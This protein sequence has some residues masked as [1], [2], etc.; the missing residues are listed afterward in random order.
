MCFETIALHD[1]VVRTNISNLLLMD[2]S[3]I[4][5]CVSVMRAL[6]I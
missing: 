3:Y 2:Y 4:E 1:V 6:K 5:A